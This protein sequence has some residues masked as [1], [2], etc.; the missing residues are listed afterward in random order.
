LVIQV[1]TAVG[2][3]LC[4]V[5]GIYLF[6]I[7][8]GFVPLLILDKRLE[9]WPAMELSRRVVNERWWEVAALMLCVTAVGLSGLLLFGVGVFLTF[10]LGVAACVYAY[11]EIFGKIDPATLALAASPPEGTSNSSKSTAT[12]AT[13]SPAA[14][15]GTT[16]GPEKPA[17]AN[18]ASPLHAESPPAA[19]RPA[20]T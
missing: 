10:P 8:W 14:P 6:V 5:P 16:P 1:L 4:I 20:Q 17:A 18:P 15:A 7:W 2:L 3:A 9:F 11:E 12:V 19:D 13:A